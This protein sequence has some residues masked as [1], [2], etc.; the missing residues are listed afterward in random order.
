MVC[1][2]TGVR[3]RTRVICNESEFGVEIVLSSANQP[4]L[5]NLC[6][7]QQ[8]SVC[9]SNCVVWSELVFVGQFLLSSAIS[10]LMPKLCCLQ[11]IRVEWEIVLSTTK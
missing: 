4:T 5:A 11:Q 6:C 9:Y 7:L 3:C 2:D 10:C 1:S 8:I